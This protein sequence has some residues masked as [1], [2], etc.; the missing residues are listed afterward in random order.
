MA[1]PMAVAAVRGSLMAGLLCEKCHPSK[2][3]KVLELPLE[4]IDAEALKG[5]VMY[6]LFFDMT[7]A[8]FC[9]DPDCRLY[10]AHWQEDLIRAQLDG[11]FEFCRKH[12]GFLNRLACLQ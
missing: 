9:D 1:C 10:N 8:L 3:K 4:M 5:Y 12:R 7:G 2:F 6:A 11:E